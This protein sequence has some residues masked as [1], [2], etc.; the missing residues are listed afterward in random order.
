MAQT[1]GSRDQLTQEKYI[2]HHHLGE[3]PGKE[4]GAQL[5][6]QMESWV[7]INNRKMT[8]LIHVY[9][10][11]KPGLMG[12]ELGWRVC[13]EQY[14]RTPVCLALHCVGSCCAD[15]R[16][17]LAGRYWDQTLVNRDKTSP[18][19]ATSGPMNQQRTKMFWVHIGRCLLFCSMAFLETA[20]KQKTV[21]EWIIFLSARG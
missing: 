20:L 14:Y 12:N 15:W 17:Q 19:A 16:L 5:A 2:K 4:A 13:A 18:V 9:R 8:L 21:K 1:W 7:A 6:W 3:F 10:L 11:G